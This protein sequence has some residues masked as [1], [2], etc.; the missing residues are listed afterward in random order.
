MNPRQ[1]TVTY[2]YR[3]TH[4]CCHLCQKP[5]NLRQGLWTCLWKALM[6]GMVRSAGVK[7][8]RRCAVSQMGHLGACKR[9]RAGRH[10][11]GKG[12]APVV[13]AY[14][15]VSQIERVLEQQ[16]ICDES[17]ATTKIDERQMKL[18]VARNACIIINRPFR[19]I[20]SHQRMNMLRCQ[21]NQSPSGG[22]VISAFALF[23]SSAYSLPCQHNQSPS[24]D[25][26]ASMTAPCQVEGQRGVSTTNPRQ[27][28]VT[29]K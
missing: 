24:G 22:T 27:G 14:D 28:T 8:L 26:D 1:G 20:C 15:G 3:C 4:T 21:H 25:C 7:R 10:I 13:T 16:M 18:T 23:R 17:D 12:G 19:S 29:W 2:R 9:Q 6:P 11:G 5:P